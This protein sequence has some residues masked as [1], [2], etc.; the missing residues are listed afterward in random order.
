MFRRVR[1][2]YGIPRRGL[3]F[4][5]VY[6]FNEPK[7][8]FIIFGIAVFAGLSLGFYS[9]FVCSE[10]GCEIQNENHLHIIIKRQPIDI[11]N[12]EGFSMH[13]HY[14]YAVMKDGTPIKIIAQ[15][16]E[17]DETLKNTA[18]RLNKG[19]EEYRNGN[20]RVNVFIH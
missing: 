4:G 6:G 2:V 7:Y 3:P 17:S 14:L 13:D 1:K 19:V 20:K 10:T 5:S 15:K 9:S 16:F 11:A 8:K 18:I 12:L